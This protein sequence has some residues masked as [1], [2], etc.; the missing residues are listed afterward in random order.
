MTHIS[1]CGHFEARI[2]DWRDPE[3]KGGCV[4]LVVKMRG[5]RGTRLI[6]YTLA[7][8]EQGWRHHDPAR[9]HP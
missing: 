3:L 9:R 5:W 4:Y 1:N 7:E 8:V 2:S 6:S